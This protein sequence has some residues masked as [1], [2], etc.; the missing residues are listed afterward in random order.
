MAMKCGFTKGTDELISD[1]TVNPRVLLFIGI[2][3]Q[4]YIFV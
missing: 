4:K 3:T 2:V 1:G